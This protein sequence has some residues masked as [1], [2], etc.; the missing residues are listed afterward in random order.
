MKISLRLLDIKI[1]VNFSL[2]QQKHL[3]INH[4]F[5]N[6]VFLLP[7]LQ[8]Y[9]NPNKHIHVLSCTDIFSPWVHVTF[10]CKNTNSNTNIHTITEANIVQFTSIYSYKRY[11]T[12]SSVKMYMRCSSHKSSYTY[13]HKHPDNNYIIPPNTYSL[14]FF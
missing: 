2:I 12:E 11:I 3:L 8:A 9:S 10:T 13:S 4:F 1:K 7:P 5:K 14:P 6:P